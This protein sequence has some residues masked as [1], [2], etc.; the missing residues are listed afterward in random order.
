MKIIQHRSIILWN[1][2]CPQLSKP[3]A[4]ATE[5]QDC[6][7]E[8]NGAKVPIVQNIFLCVQQKKETYRFGAT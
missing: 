5:R 7:D 2:K 8:V 6:R 4:K 1:I 3:K